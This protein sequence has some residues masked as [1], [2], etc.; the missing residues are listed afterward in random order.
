MPPFTEKLNILHITARS[1]AGGGPEVIR[2]LIAGGPPDLRHFVASPANPPYWERW[3]S[4]LHDG[5]L[6]AIPDRSFQLGV[7]PRLSRFAEQASIHLIH[8]HGFGAGLYARPLA[9]WLHI[10]CLHTFH[11]YYP[12][13]LSGFVRQGLENLLAPLTTAG[14]AVSSSEAARIGCGVP[15]LRGRL[16]VV[17]NGVPAPDAPIPHHP[18]GSF[19]IVAINRLEPQKNP[20]ALVRIAA[21]CARR[22]GHASFQLRIIGEG[23]LRPAVER[24]ILRQGLTSE[25]RLLGALPDCRQELAAASLFLSTARWEGMS[26]A[27]LEAMS[28]HVVP[29]VPRVMGNIDVVEDSVNGVLFQPGDLAGAAESIRLL[30]HDEARRTRLALAAAASIARRFPVS[31]TIGAYA[32]LYRALAAVEQRAPL[33][34][35]VHP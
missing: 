14:I 32:A 19:R 18:A 35:E 26:L 12:R 1:D 5:S 28:Q 17:P 33:T 30:A 4:L 3:R 16:T 13:G 11:G 6:Q 20:L 25:V 15:L 31:G 24:E 7:L 21:L 27:L 10:P 2:Q 23:P 29:V 22:M 9:A 8:S 34:A